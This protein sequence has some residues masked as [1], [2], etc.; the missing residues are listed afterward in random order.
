MP[1]SPASHKS[2]ISDI[3]ARLDLHPGTVRYYEKVGL[4]HPSRSDGGYRIYADSDY[5]RLRFIMRAKE[6]NLT[7][8]EIGEILSLH[9]KGEAPCGQVLRLLDNKVA[10]IDARIKQLTSLRRE[11][12]SLRRGSAKGN[13]SGS[14]IC[15]I[16]EWRG[17][18]RPKRS[19]SS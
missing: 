1:K 11:L 19:E 2:L 15:P 13:Q 7:L 8:T 16:L 12:L 14:T 3:G 10:V 9:D 5:Q 18:S 4:I 17:R 6:L